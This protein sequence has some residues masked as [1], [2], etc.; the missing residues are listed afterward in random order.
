MRQILDLNHS[1]RHLVDDGEI[2]EDGEAGEDE[3][4]D[5]LVHA[6]IRYD[7]TGESRAVQGD[8]DEQTDANVAL[9]AREVGFDV[10]GPLPASDDENPAALAG[11][12]CSAVLQ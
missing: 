7:R 5:R 11:T 3:G 12:R 9:S 4:E 10:A 8:G 1:G 6:E 2:H